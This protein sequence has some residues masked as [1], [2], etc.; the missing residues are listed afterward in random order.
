ML[1][2][3]TATPPT[4]ELPRSLGVK[5]FKASS[6]SS[7]QPQNLPSTRRFQT[8][9]CQHTMTSFSHLSRLR[10]S[11]FLPHV[12]LQCRLKTVSSL[13]AQSSASSL[14]QAVR[15]ASSARPRRRTPS[16]MALSP[17]VAQ[18]TVKYGEKR[19]SVRHQNGPFG[20]MNQRRANLRDRQR[21]RSQAELKRTS[22]KK[23]KDDSEKKQPELFKAL[24]MQTALSSVSYGRRTSIKSKIS[25]I[26]SFDQFDLLPSVRQS[27]YDSALPGLEYVTP[28]PIQRLAIPAILR[29]GSAT[30]RPEE[31]QEDMPRFD[32][33]LLAAETGSG[34]TLAYLLPVV[35]A[36]KRTE[37]KDKEEEERMAKEELKKE[38][39]QAGEKNQNLFELES[40]GEEEEEPINAPKS[41]VK[42]KAII[43]VPTSELVEQIGR[44]VKQLAHTVKY[45]S[46]LLA[47]NYTPRKIRRTLFNPNGLDILVT[48]PYLVASIAE[49]N[50]YIFSR[51]THLVVDEADSLFDKS[52]SPK[53]NTIIDRTAPT[54]KQLI[55]CSATIPRS[56]DNRLRERFPQIRRLVTPNLHAIP[57]RVQL[58][59]VDIDKEPYRGRRH[60][61]CAD[62]I[63]SI[64][65]SGNPYD[66]D[67]GYQVTGQKEPKSIIVFVNERE[68]AAEVAEFLVTKG[69]NAV[70]LTRDT[71]EKRQAQILAEFTT[72]KNPPQPE[73]YKMLKGNRSDDDSVP[74]VNVRPGNERSNRLSNTKVL[75]VTDLGSRGID[76]VAVK[77]VILYDV[78]HSTIDF[79][80]RLGRLGRMGRRGRGIV[81][82]GKKDRK[83]V[84]R[85]VREA[86]YRGQALI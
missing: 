4:F 5:I 71:S 56:L 29:Q 54:L 41:V 24:K 61:A 48:T 66:A 2:V 18:S 74:F 57:R 19:K 72:E 8:A 35:D 77:T 64:G 36:I 10:M 46:A 51:V 68:T 32:Q 45:R 26:T 44:I 38:Q 52:F 81:L 69:I 7:T 27:V 14:L 20:G 13:P 79:I 76:T 43:L 15:H 49:A 34:K 37:A 50:P 6:P 39:E 60:L 59:V 30:P 84:V 21:P 42:P 58:G 83:D 47:S 65:R 70:S 11:A 73:D 85:E 16:R 9:C 75:V 63:W 25:N 78:P 67:V 53:T 17:N 23:D 40:P 12:C 31:G 3:G 80:H 86:M 62:A 28:T 55:L 1:L 33:Y 82:V 22:F